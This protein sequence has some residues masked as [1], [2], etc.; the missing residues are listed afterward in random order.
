MLSFIYNNCYISML[1]LFH[2]TYHRTISAEKVI[3]FLIIFSFVISLH[4]MLSGKILH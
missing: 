4:R 1:L 3:F 2:N